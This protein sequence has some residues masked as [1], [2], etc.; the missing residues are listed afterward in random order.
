[1][2]YFIKFL[3]FLWVIWAV[4][5]IIIT[6]FLIIPSIYIILKANPKDAF[7]KA[8]VFSKLYAK[9]IAIFV[10]IR[11]KVEGKKRIDKKKAYVIISNHQSQLD[12][13]ACALSNP[14]GFRFL[15]KEQLLKLPVFGF[16]IKNL[17][18]TVNRESKAARQ[19]SMEDMKASLAEG[20]SVHIYPEGTRNRSE[21]LL[22]SFYDGAFRLAIEA[23]VPLAILT[24]KNSKELN[25]PD[26]F[27]QLSPG[28]VRC[29]WSEPIE[30]NSMTI[31][32]VSQL[33]G[34]ARSII[35]EQ[36]QK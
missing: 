32:D 3:K 7:W 16:M 25:A 18:L 23:Q 14:G 5:I 12:I 35:L 34:K 33:K 26:Q 29:R 8:H 36:L 30:T 1:M 4:I 11:F 2:T 15:S 17:Y 9:I 13:L 24:I 27:P 28:I 6:A 31:E 19:K 10:L 21:D 22:K 20:I